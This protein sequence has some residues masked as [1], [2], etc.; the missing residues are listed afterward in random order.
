MTEKRATTEKVKKEAKK[1]QRQNRSQEPQ[2][3]KKEKE[4]NEP[5][6]GQRQNRRRLRLRMIPIWLRILLSIVLIGGSFIVGLMVGYAVVGEGDN[7][8]E[9][10][11][12]DIW[13]Y[14]IDLIRG[15]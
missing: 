3:P 8:G 7:P 6:S 14:L 15:K 12:P 9:I 2:Q 13:Y 1:E 4:P 11:K 10:L 5:K